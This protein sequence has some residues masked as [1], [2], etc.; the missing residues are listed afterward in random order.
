MSR[1]QMTAKSCNYL[2]TKSARHPG[3]AEPV[4]M[5]ID[6]LARLTAAECA[7]KTFLGCSITHKPAN[8][9]TD[10]HGQHHQRPEPP[11]PPGEADQKGQERVGGE[12]RPIQIEDGETAL[13]SRG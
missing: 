3:L 11:L 13:P 12:Q 6:P 4:G 7:H 9:Q 2:R 8:I 1:F 5:G 10:I